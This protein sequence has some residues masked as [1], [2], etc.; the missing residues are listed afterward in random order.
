LSF[1][2]SLISDPAGFVFASSLAAVA[3]IARLADH[4]APESSR[5]SAG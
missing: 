3:I 5:S 1:A 2:T 4:R